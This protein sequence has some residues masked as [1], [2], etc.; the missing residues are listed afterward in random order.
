M[1]LFVAVFPSFCLTLGLSAN[2]LILLLSA[3]FTSRS[4]FFC[5]FSLCLLGVSS[6]LV[7]Y[8]AIVFFESAALT[9]WLSWFVF[10]F[11][12]LL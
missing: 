8:T 2:F 7:A 12:F 10:F 5:Y 11:A 1:L 3:Y 6:F 9:S 4:S